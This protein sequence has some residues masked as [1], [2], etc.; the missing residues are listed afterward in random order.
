MIKLDGTEAVRRFCNV[1]YAVDDYY[2]EP[3]PVASPS[4]T[5][6]MFASNWDKAGGQVNAYVVD[7]RGVGSDTTSTT[8]YATAAPAPAAP[9]GL[10]VVP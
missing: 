3:Q 7:A 2:A 4:G 10:T 1:H 8:T 6:V 5:R 9:Q